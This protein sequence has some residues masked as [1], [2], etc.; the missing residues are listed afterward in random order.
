MS[1]H[2]RVTSVGPSGAETVFGYLS[3]L[4]FHPGTFVAPFFEEAHAMAPRVL[5]MMEAGAAIEAFPPR[6]VRSSTYEEPANGPDRRRFPSFARERP[7]DDLAA[8]V[9]LYWR[10]AL[11]PAELTG[12]GARPRMRLKEQPGLDWWLWHS[13]AGL[14][15]AFRLYLPDGSPCEAYDLSRRPIGDMRD[16]LSLSDNLSAI[17]SL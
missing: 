8:V 6:T 12:R 7:A 10:E 1:T 3:P 2:A 13:P 15:A 9:W 16:A 5:G 17:M 11:H 4:Q 14:D